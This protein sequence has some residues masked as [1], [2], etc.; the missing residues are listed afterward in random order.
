MHGVGANEDTS[1]AIM[2]KSLDAGINFFD[3]ADVYALTRPVF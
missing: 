1:F 2:D 3:T